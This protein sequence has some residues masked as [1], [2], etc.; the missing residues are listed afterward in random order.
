MENKKN[1]S[2]IKIGAVLS[3]III[4]LNMVVGIVYTPILTNALGQSEYGLYSLVSTIISYLTILDFGFGNAIIIY[5]SKY[6]TKGEIAK[7]RK[8]HGMFFVIY[9][10][11]GIV[12]GFIGII[13]ALN[14]NKIFGRSMTVEEIEKAKKL[15]IILSFNLVFTFAFSIYSSIITA[16]EKFI[17]QKLIN[18]FRIILQP[19]IMLVLLHYGYRSV[20]L[21]IVITILNF[22]TL[23]ANAFYCKT[24]L[25]IKFTFGK[26][27]K[28]LFLEIVSYSVWIFLNTIMDK[29]NWSL[30]QTIL[31][32]VSG[33]VMVSIYSI[34]GQLDQMYLSFSTAISNVL[35]PKVAKMEANKASDEE[36]TDIF[37]K[38]GRI[39]YIVLA[40][41][42]S[43]FILFG[44]E[45][46]NITWVGHDYD[47][48]YFIALVLMIPLTYPLIQNMGLNII[49]AKNQY[50][51]RVKVLFIFAIF[52]AVISDFF[53]K[54]WGGI[55]AAWGTSLSI[56]M[57]QGFFMNWFYY[58]K[59]HIDIPEFWKQILKMTILIVICTCIGWGIKSVW[60]VNSNLVLFAQILIYC[61]IYAFIMYNF[62]MNNY[63]RDLFTK[64]FKKLNKNA[65]TNK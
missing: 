5:T 43:G 4:I 21:V 28:V 23:L 48:S 15:M 49:Q 62:G 61:V 58:K 63:E 17:F 9:L 10:I 57:G 53:A 50:K 26:F 41:I 47:Q 39:Q 8:L 3:Y 7:E 22:A 36:F 18:I 52:K 51:Y 56:I 27:D 13:I 6:H 60:K 32:I 29:I 31:G 38:T 65:K 19:L 30:D 37:I 55:G 11:I 46:I 64:P 45:F 44:R 35:L 14:V 1:K 20:A 25:N 42:M 12:A 2:E 34:A 24:R 16:Y 40:I 59:T 33:T 54:K